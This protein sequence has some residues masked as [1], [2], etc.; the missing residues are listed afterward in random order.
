VS[1]NLGREAAAIKSPR[2]F[3]G[4]LLQQPALQLAYDTAPIGLA[5]LSPDCRYLQINQRLTEICGISVEDHLGHSVRDCVPALADAVEGIVRSIMSTGEPVAGIEVT[6]QRT[7][8]TEER[9]WVTYWHP[10]RNPNGEIIG[11]N[12]A[13]EEVT[14]RKR[15]E[16]VLA[17]NG[18]ALRESESRFRE[19]A[20][21]ISQFAWT[22][23]ASGWIYW[24]NK[25][26]HDYAGTT[27]EEMQGWGWQK[28]HHPEHVDRVV[29]RIRRS[30]ETGTPWEDTF[31]LR[32]KDGNYRWFLSRALPIRNEAGEV[33]RWFG[34]N[35]DVTEQIE[36]ENAL[37]VSV[38]RQTAT[39]D[40]LKVIA[41][42]P[43]NVRPVFE[44]I[45]ERSNRLT[46]GHST[47]VVRIINDIVE[48]VAFTSVSPE[49]D[50]ALQDSF[51]RPVTAYPL[52]ELVRGGQVLEIPDTESEL[53]AQTGT[54]DFGRARGFRSLLLTP[55]SNEKGLIGLI[56][57]T[58]KEPGPFAD[59]HV[60]LLQTFADQAV[61]AI[62]NVRLF[63]EV[64]QR[65][66]ELSQSL[67]DLHTAQDRLIQTEK[68]AALGRLVAGVAH[69]INTPIGTSL[70][71]ASSLES[72]T[73]T[74]ATE[75]ARGNLRR[76]TLTEFLEASRA[77]SSQLIANL[78]HAAELIQSFKQVAT[79]QSYTNPRVFDLGQL[80]EEIAKSLRPG[81]RK[82]D[83]TLNVNCQP[84]LVLN[85][86]PGPYGQVLTNLFLNATAHAFQDATPGIIAI[87]VQAAG[88][89]AVEILFS[90]DGCGM[91]TDVWRKAFDPFF[92][93][94]RD[95]GNTGLGLHIVHSIVTNCLGGTLHLD[96]EPGGGTKI[97]LRLP[98][99]APVGAA[100]DA[101]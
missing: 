80:T 22:A 20:D 44:A 67:N 64:K 97:K 33:I 14:E 101:N 28:V 5:V 92:T 7:D 74:F 83:L 4:S 78:N 13:A 53:G 71:V 54:R 82:R 27:L 73:A 51:P 81:L 98:R 23:D 48:L 59:H 10:L 18:Q 34:T 49:A 9:W 89:D 31:P 37:R 96:S 26:W 6:S 24:Y 29:E 19:L 99:V 30:F 68:L 35:T 60:Q 15:A 25:R 52:F 11:V 86:H 87:N 1:E 55:L 50:A 57:V 94:S 100:P 12:V 40:I 79:D 41:S 66:E 61:I 93:T 77:A 62:E 70:T 95:Q 17:A 46:G 88:D 2:I 39:A 3:D 43:S 65:T 47:A 85:S 72:K 32:G 56:S 8:K 16:A 76:S 75:A 58:R 90:D 38:E 36:A 84:N 21:N 42:S 63:D 91:T 69:E 45:A